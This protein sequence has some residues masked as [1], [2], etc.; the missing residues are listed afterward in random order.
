MLVRTRGSKVVRAGTLTL[1]E[2]AAVEEG[3]KS[4]N[5]DLRVACGYALGL[6]DGEEARALATKLVVDRFDDVRDAAQFGIL[7][8]ELRHKVAPIRFARL[9]QELESSTSPLYRQFTVNW[10]GAEFGVES[11]PILTQILDT[12]VEQGVLLETMYFLM[13]NGGAKERSNVH[14]TVNHFAAGHR[15]MAQG[16]VPT[17]IFALL[18]P[19][20]WPEMGKD[21]A[22]IRDGL[23]DPEL[24]RTK[25]PKSAGPKSDLTRE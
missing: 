10:L 22:T 24:G 20:P 11:L 7:I 6:V 16:E 15:L 23:A 8:S 12:E 2:I 18:R 5:K 9:L 14:R 25:R 19:G 21:S 1:A 13:V 4:G 3:A 17:S